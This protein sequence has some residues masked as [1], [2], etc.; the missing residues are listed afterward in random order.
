MDIIASQTR[1]I[2]ITGNC[3]CIIG[4]VGLLLILVRLLIVVFDGIMN[5][6][7]SRI[8]ATEDI[9]YFRENREKLKEAVKKQK[10]F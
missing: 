3:F 8:S 2:Y 5:M 10:V 6:I 4:G 7:L 9:I 1:I